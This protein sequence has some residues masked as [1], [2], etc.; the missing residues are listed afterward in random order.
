[1]SKED[2]KNSIRSEFDALEYFQK[3]FQ[4]V[5]DQRLKCFGLYFTVSVASWIGGITLFTRSND[6]TALQ[7]IGAF[8][9]LISAAFAAV[10]W[11][12]QVLLSARR[13]AM[14]L[15]EDRYFASEPDRGLRTFSNIELVDFE[16]ALAADKKNTYGKVFLDVI[17]AKLTRCARFSVVFGAL[18]VLQF[19]VGLVMICWPML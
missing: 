19:C 12:N 14:I 9:L 5:S 4:Y 15:L 17:K 11:R 16:T 3:Q 6:D 7:F 10:D 8:Q 13:Q 1:M 2:S 18:F